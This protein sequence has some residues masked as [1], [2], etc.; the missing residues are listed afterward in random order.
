MLHHLTGPAV[1]FVS[2]WR[3]WRKYTSAVG[4]VMEQFGTLVSESLSLPLLVVV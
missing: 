2:Q 3:E 4:K 1:A